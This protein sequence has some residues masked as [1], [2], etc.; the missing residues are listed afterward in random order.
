MAPPEARSSR[1]AW[2]S[3]STGTLSPVTAADGARAES[4]SFPQQRFQPPPDATEIVLVRHGQSQPYVDGQLFELVDGHGDPP[5]SPHGR[6]QAQRVCAR[7]TSAGIDAIYATTLRRT[8]E[9]AA[10]L[11]ADIGLEVGV[12]PGLREVYLGE[13]EGGVLRKMV[14][15]GDPISHRMRAEERWDVIP[16]AEPADA[17]A[18]RVNDAI[19]RLAAR[20]QGQRVAAFTHGGVIGQALALAS[21]SRPFAFIG[22]DNGSIS[23]LVITPER[24]ILRSYN[25]TA[26]LDEA[27]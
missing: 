14:A 23:R 21:A 12:E 1:F 18:G 10:P 17:F 11:A 27:G 5:L 25:D 7:L 20:H 26:H 24:W 15:S 8:A 19:L 9:T 2:P 16:G 13:W 6:E 22:A 4:A 3:L